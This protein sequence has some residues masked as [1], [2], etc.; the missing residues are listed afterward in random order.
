MYNVSHFPSPEALATARGKSSL[1][2]ATC[3]FKNISGTWLEVSV[4]EIGSKQRGILPSSQI[5][6]DRGFF[7]SLCSTEHDPS[8]RIL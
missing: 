7:A 8:P 6:K 1:G 3:F 2:C 5:G 4:H